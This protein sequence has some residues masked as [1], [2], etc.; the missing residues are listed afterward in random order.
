[1]KFAL[2]IDNI[3]N[4][5]SYFVKDSTAYDLKNKKEYS[6]EGSIGSKCFMNTWN[7]PWLFDGYFINWKDYESNLP[8]LDLDVIFVTIERFLDKYDWCNVSTLRK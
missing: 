8:K 4:C 6:Y 3:S 2:I 5:E 7:Y 1:M